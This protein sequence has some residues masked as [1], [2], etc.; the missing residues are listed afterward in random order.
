MVKKNFG[1]IAILMISLLMLIGVV[2]Y[3]RCNL[4]LPESIKLPIEPHKM[5]Y[6][7][8]VDSLEIYKDIIAPGENLSVILKRFGINSSIIENVAKKSEHIFDIR[9]IKAGNLYTVLSKNDQSQTARYFIYEISPIEYLVFDLGDSINVYRKSRD[10]IN[11]VSTASGTIYSSLWNAMQKQNLDPALAMNLSEVYQWTIDFFSLQKGDHFK[12]I[13][14]E[15]FVENKSIGISKIYAAEFNH[16]GKNNYAFYFEQDSIGDYFDE[17][18]QSLRRTFLKAPLRFSRISSPFS[19]SRMHPVL[20]IRRPHHGVDYAAPKGTPVQALGNGKI[21]ELRFKGGYG[22]YILIRHN[23]IYSTGYA[24]LSG[25]G[26]GLKQGSV[27]RQGDIIGYVG[28]TGLSTGP[29]LDFRVYKNGQP[30]DPLKIES[31][32]AE[33]V[34][35]TNIDSFYVFS[36]KIMT[37][38]NLIKQK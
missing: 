10:V 13:Y 4:V 14:S 24:H 37:N 6:G 5:E 22:K 33:P 16:L 12:V 34:K 35:P 30:I 19:N 1:S 23:T 18:G 9:R 26:K 31:P 11:R 15:Q 7:I 17:N 27:V 2:Y 20:R 32:P 38:L 8:P 29:H 36:K 28:S 3:D 25:Y 21:A